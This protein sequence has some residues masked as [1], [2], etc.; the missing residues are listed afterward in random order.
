MDPELFWQGHYSNRQENPVDGPSN[1]LGQVD[2]G[3][4]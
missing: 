1:S 3:D 2:D 4:A